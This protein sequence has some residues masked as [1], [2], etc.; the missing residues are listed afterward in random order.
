MCAVCV[1]VH[2]RVLVFV[3]ARVCVAVCAER[4]PLIDGR[5]QTRSVQD[6]YGGRGKSARDGFRLMM[7]T[8]GVFVR[9]GPP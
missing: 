8:P 9:A 3:R 1:R 2:V 7:G 5:S 4:L 6:H